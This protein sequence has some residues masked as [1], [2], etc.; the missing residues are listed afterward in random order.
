MSLCCSS[1]FSLVATS[2][3]CS[4]CCVQASPCGGFSP[5]RTGLSGCGLGSGG[6]QALEHRLRSCGARA[7]LLWGTWS[8]PNPEIKPVSPELASRLFTTEPPGKAQTWDSWHGLSLHLGSVFSFAKWA[9]RCLPSW[10]TMGFP[11]GSTLELRGVTESV[12]LCLEPLVGDKQ[13]F[14]ITYI[15]PSS[16]R[17]RGMGWGGENHKA[18]LTKLYF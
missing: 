9:Q 11:A 8:R 16:L 4:V 6:A 15:L 1:S 3:G 17:V 10:V 12:S 13:T 2:G 7:Q 14:A 18:Y 5:C